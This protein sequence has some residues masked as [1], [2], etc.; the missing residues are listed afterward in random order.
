L[1]VNG[2]SAGSEGDFAFV[3]GNGVEITPDPD[4]EHT[5]LIRMTRNHETVKCGA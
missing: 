5:V 2:L 3:G 4:N 1:R